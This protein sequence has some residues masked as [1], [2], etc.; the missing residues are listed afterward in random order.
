MVI[1]ID[2][3]IGFLC[4]ISDSGVSSDSEVVFFGKIVLNVFPSSNILVAMNMYLYYHF[5]F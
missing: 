3:E 5:L 4:L 1:V 2:K